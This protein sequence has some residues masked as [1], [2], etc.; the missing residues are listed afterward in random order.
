MEIKAKTEHDPVAA[1]YIIEAYMRWALLAIEEVIGPRG[2]A[3]VLRDA[4]LERLIDNYPPDEA[5]ISDSLTFGDYANLGAELLTFFGRGSRGMLRRVGRLSA[6]HGIREQSGL[7]GLATVLAS[8]VL[9]L[10]I[11]IKVALSH[12]QSGFIKLNQ[13]AGQE[14][15]L[16]LDDLGDRLAYVDHHC[17]QCAGQAAD[18][19]ICLIR[20]G[21]LQEALHWVTGKE[22]EVHETECRAM[23]AP[24]CIW[25]I[26]KKPKA[27]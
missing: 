24:A 22:F 25:H 11:Q 17:W 1:L 3:V 21:T 12:M 10:P 5:R 6:Q 23:G 9:P 7:F 19:P 2:M 18:E 20:A 8:K 4:G 15:Q 26:A 13:E 14:V 27:E 16:H